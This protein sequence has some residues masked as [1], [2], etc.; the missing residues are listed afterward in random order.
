MTP[1]SRH[2]DITN[3]RTIVGGIPLIFPVFGTPGDLRVS[4]SGC[5][6]QSEHL[7]SLKTLPHHGFAR[8]LA[9]DVVELMGDAVVMR[10]D[11]DMVDPEVRGGWAEG[12]RW[13]VVLRWV[14][15]R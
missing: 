3:S 10:L 11:Q 13:E 8:M 15:V 7:K 5:G 12:G 1:W 14:F 2:Q 6:Q 4:G 9:W